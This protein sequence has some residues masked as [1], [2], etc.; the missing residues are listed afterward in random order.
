MSANTADRDALPTVGGMLLEGQL[1]PRAH[2][3]RDDLAFAVEWLEAY[4]PDADDDPNAVRLATVAAFLRA[5]I[6]R[7]DTAVFVRTLTAEMVKK[8]HDVKNKRIAAYIQVAA[9]KAVL[10]RGA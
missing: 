6:Q 2:V 8:G 7:R 4:E 3:V 9:K 5:E 1:E 10:E